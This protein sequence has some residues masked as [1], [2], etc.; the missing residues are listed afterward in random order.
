MVFM[1]NIGSL[2]KKEFGRLKTDRRTLFLIFVIPLI[3]II[4][5]GLT[6]G[7][8]PTMHYTVSIITEDDQYADIFTNQTAFYDDLFISVVRGNCSAFT[9]YNHTDTQDFFNATSEDDFNTSLVLAKQLIRDEKID[10][11]II[12]PANFSE[13]VRN[14]SNPCISYIGDGTDINVIDGFETALSE[15]IMM[16]KLYSQTYVNFTVMYPSLEYDVPFYK[17]EVLNYALPMILPL[18]I[19][20]LN[21]NLTSL[22]IVTETPLPRMILTPSGKKDFIISKLIAYNLIMVIQVIEIFITLN[23]FEFYCRGDLFNFFMSLLL[24]GFV[25]N[26]MGMAISALAQTPQQANQMFIM[27]F[28]MVTLFSNAFLPIDLMPKFM[29]RIAMFF[30]LTHAIPIIRDITLRGFGLESDHTGY[31]VILSLVYIII[32]YIAFARKKVEV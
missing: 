21:M 30:P 1:A 11:V 28:I 4:I 8:E 9:L 23:F 16:F 10:A 31:L 2:I 15:P 25:G 29:G 14:G 5:F 12:L 13:T 32:A 22:C 24:A 27:L 17:S 6:S 18:L 20:G 19:I 7:G 26:A 3:L